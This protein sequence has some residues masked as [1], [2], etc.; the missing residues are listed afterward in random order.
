MC[1][2]ICVKVSFWS[3]FDV[4][5]SS[6]DEDMH[7]KLFSFVHSDGVLDL[8]FAP[9]VTLVQCCVSTKLEVSTAFLFIENQRNKTDRW[10]GCNAQCSP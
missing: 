6:F 1:S 10:M 2:T 3:W 7:G 9:L 8:K 5:R 4:N